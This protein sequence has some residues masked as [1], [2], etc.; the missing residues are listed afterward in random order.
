M[1][2]FRKTRELSEKEMNEF[3]Q[4]MA[5]QNEPRYAKRE[6][7]DTSGDTD[8]LNGSAKVQ[9]DP[10][11]EPEK[12]EAEDL[13]EPE[14]K[15]PVGRTA[16]KLTRAEMGSFLDEQCEN[17]LEGSR[18]IEGIRK[19]YQEVTAYL[20]DT[21]LIERANEEEREQIEDAAR[22]ILTL[23][24]DMDKLKRRRTNLTDHQYRTLERYEH[25]IPAEIRRLEEEEEY[26]ALIKSDLQKLEG[27]KGALVYEE[28]E[29]EKKHQFIHRLSILTGVATTLMTAMYL[30]L[31]FGL[32]VKVVI[33]FLVTI[34]GALLMAVYLF[35]ETRNNQY[36]RRMN[37]RKKNRLI[38]LQNRVKIKYVNNTSSL[39]YSYEKYAVNNSRELKHHW[40]Q[41]VNMK[42]DIGRREQ[43]LEVL[44]YYEQQLFLVLDELKL[45]DS[46]I[47]SRQAEALIDRREM[48]EIRHRLNVR[49]QKLREHL[50]YNG[51]LREHAR[52]ELRQFRE[53]YPQE[54]ERL[55]TAMRSHGVTI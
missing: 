16:Q 37:I 36:A 48:V 45:H 24:K 43:S 11:E 10:Q 26:R 6:E 33:P 12:E 49:R 9:D 42:D 50:E 54:R 29:L 25:I 2:L 47:W 8:W 5:E 1:R 14:K 44:R 4:I 13:Q 15:I 30:F 21:Q 17:I 46:D 38:T 32:E 28:E 40:E 51:Q 31:W 27:E 18:Q 35:Y 3:V 20:Q 19:E 55:E 52:E 23:K 41:Y 22:H 7:R 34:G 39:D 53:L